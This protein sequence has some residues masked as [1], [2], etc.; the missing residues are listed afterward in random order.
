MS[1][2]VRW[3]ECELMWLSQAHHLFIR[4]LVLIVWLSLYNMHPFVY[5]Y[6]IVN[7]V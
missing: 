2:E 5:I 7:A 6:V 3:S 1:H 4:F